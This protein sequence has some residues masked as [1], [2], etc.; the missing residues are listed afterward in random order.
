MEDMPENSMIKADMIVS[1]N[2]IARKFNPGALMNHGVIM[3]IRLMFCSSP[4]PMRP[5]LQNRLPA[6]LEKMNGTEMKQLNMYPTLMLEKF[7]DAYLRSRP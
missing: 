7:P 5:L 2:T 4:A 6:F 1:M 3:A